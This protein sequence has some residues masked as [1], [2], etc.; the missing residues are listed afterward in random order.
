MPPLMAPP[1]LQL[2]ALNSPVATLPGV[3]AAR[4]AQFERLG[5]R[6]CADLLL[7]RPRRHEDRRHI[8]AIVDAPRGE[9][10]LLNGTIVAH[11]V[12]RFRQ[13]TKSVYE[14]I[15]EDGSGRLHCRWWNLPW[16]ENLFT[17]GARVFVHGKIGP[18]KPRN[19]DHPEVE[20]VEED[21]EAPVHV[22]R[23]VPVYPLTEGLPQRWLRSL[24]H[25]CLE[26]ATDEQLG[27]LGR[28]PGRS[29]ETA[30]AI[31]QLHFPD[32]PEAA[33]TSR[34][35]LALD[36]FYELQR[37]LLARRDRF[38]QRAN[39]IPCQGDN[40]LIRPFL[41]GL[42]FSPTSAQTSVLKEI[43]ADLGGRHPMRRLLHGDVGAGKTVVA[44]CAALMTIESGHAVAL[45]SPTEVLAEQHFLKFREWF[46]PLGLG[47]RF[48]SGGRD[49]TVPGNPPDR[50]SLTIGTH[51]LLHGQ[52]LPERLGLVIIDEQHRFGVLQREQLLKKGVYPHL[53]VMTATPIPRTLGLT[54]YG[55]LDFS[56]MRESP[57][58]RG[59]TRTF[60]RTSEQLPKVWKFVREK[61]G[62]GGQAF[63]VYPRIEDGDDA[64]TGAVLSALPRLADA[65]RPHRV[66]LVHGRMPAAETREVMERFRRNELQV[67]AATTVIEVGVDV[68]NANVMV[69]ENAEQFGL[70][71]LHQLRGRIGR[72]GGD[73]CC[74]LISDATQPETLER[75]NVLVNTADGF[76][77]AEAD[78]RHRGPG[79]F[80]G[81]KQSGL[82]KLRFGDLLNDRDLLIEA[83]R[84]AEESRK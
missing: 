7:H 11:G 56:V 70:A 34:K 4:V 3:N 32:E 63:V 77:I 6:T 46:E 72:G 75:L 80:L 58:G 31:R 14:M 19:M 12:K 16:M 47:L 24:V 17:P 50:P 22:R 37:G 76:A 82:P 79:D 59:R 67:L 38:H 2:P 84:L 71:Q 62:G 33:E 53:L 39:R 73:A 74:I 10:V 26:S 20:T 68:P 60:L 48:L 35:V 61:L 1:L 13:G 21:E 36:E 42:G 57:S 23:I 44:A 45:M 43:R 41:A 51:A 28:L 9:A 18:G 25:R 64:S 54:L 52:Y 69:V 15:V 30:R 27:T 5:I 78:F 8:V 40:S 49:E 83:R 29:H 65:L 55:D 81:V 66:G